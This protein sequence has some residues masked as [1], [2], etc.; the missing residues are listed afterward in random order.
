MSFLKR[1]AVALLLNAAALWVADWIF[2]GVLIDGWVPLLIGAGVFALINTLLKP[3][4][5]ILSIPLILITLGLF[6]LVI[7]LALL[8]LTDWIVSDFDIEG[9]WTYVGTVV[10]VWLVNT[11]L[12]KLLD[13]D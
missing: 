10:V 13:L 4:L 3:V 7:N 11:V 12:E 1:L 5:V 2:D 8:G 6:L 9:F